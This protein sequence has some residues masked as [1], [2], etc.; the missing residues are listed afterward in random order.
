MASASRRL[1]FNYNSAV[2]TV[3]SRGKLPHWDEHYAIYFVTFRLADSLPQSVLQKF[4]FEWRNIIATAKLP[5]E[6]CRHSKELDSKN[7]SASRSNRSS[8]PARVAAFSQT[9]P[10]KN[11]IGRLR[12]SWTIRKRRGW[13]PLESTCRH[14]S[15]SIL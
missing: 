2:P 6:L 7:S 8:I 12:T 15:L 10:K 14:A 5:A 4:E 3:R 1:F 9:P 11:S 13:D